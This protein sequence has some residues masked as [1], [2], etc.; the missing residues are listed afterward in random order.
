[1][2]AGQVVRLLS[3]R[4]GWSV[5]AR[6]VIRAA[7]PAFV[8]NGP[9]CFQRCP[10]GYKDDGAL[11]RKDAI[12]VAKASYGRGAGEAMNFIPVA[13]S[14]QISTPKDTPVTFQMLITDLNDDVSQ[15]NDVIVVQPFQHGSASADKLYTPDPGFE[16]TD[17]RVWKWSDGKH[18]SNV[19]IDLPS[20]RQC[21]T[22]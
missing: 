1:M 18:E 2:A 15:G 19:A 20:G 13:D 3:V 17:F 21:S 9:V 11:C 8:G 5:T 16:S 10:G 22:E 4:R 7:P 6:S 14:F 12:I